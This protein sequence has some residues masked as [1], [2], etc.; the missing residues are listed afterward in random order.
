M[1]L[2]RAMSRGLVIGAVVASIFGATNARGQ[3]ADSEKPR[4]KLAPAPDTI[5][6]AP[7]GMAVQPVRTSNGTVK[8]QARMTLPTTNAVSNPCASSSRTQTRLGMM[9]NSAAYTHCDFP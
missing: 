9:N 6:P 7:K 3:I 4:V 8:P 5:K 2:A 1:T